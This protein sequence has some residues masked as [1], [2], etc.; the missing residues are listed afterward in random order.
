MTITEAQQKLAKKE[1][2]A[3]ELV[4]DCLNKIEK[5]DQGEVNIN[6][7]IT[8]NKEQALKEAK[9][10]DEKLAQNKRLKSLEGIPIAVKDVI[11]T[12]DLRSTAASKIL[13][14]YIPTYNATAV[15]RLKKQGAIIIAKV[16]HDEFAH[17]ASGENSAYGPT[18]NPYDLDRVPGGSSSGSGA[19]VAYGGALAALGTETGG[20]VRVPA[21]FNGL[22]GLKP[23]YGLV[24]R[25]GLMA[26]CS[27]TDIVSPIT[28]NVYDSAL[29]LGA[30][31]G[32]DPKDST[33]SG[34][35]GKNFT[36][37]FDKSNKGLKIAYPKE[38]FVEGLD[39]QVKAIFLESI[40]KFKKQGA[41][42]EE[43]TLPLF[44]KPALATYY[45]I[46]FSEISSNLSKFD[47]IRFGQRDEAA[48]NLKEQY[49]KTREK[50]IGKESKRRIMLGNFALSS[51]YYDAYYKKAQQVRTLIKAQFKK[52]FEKYDLV[53]T[54]TTATPAFKL[55]AKS[56]PLSMY[57]VD[58]F[59]S[60]VNLAG[61]PAVSVNAGYVDNNP[62]KTIIEGKHK[63]QLPVGL[64][65]MAKWWDEET[66]LRA[67]FNFHDYK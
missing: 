54:P 28:N 9:K 2:S 32:K 53:I 11:C 55:G 33:S 24:S 36:R 21:S 1:I 47:G 3:Y 62:K 52:V 65:M 43:I 13:D 44:G 38:A 58:I 12:K 6:A 60:S 19:I 25:Y 48:K 50:Y 57:L 41:T 5:Y 7:V 31:A 61:F 15:E 49:F 45:I 10:V 67:A 66:L 20:S 29:V 30:M 51:G 27:S 59:M 42:V 14:N 37:D 17:G 23:T 16:N 4:S 46:V 39:P 26:M 22:V 64:Q 34:F 63:N 18:K 35:E 8:L 40:E 56:D